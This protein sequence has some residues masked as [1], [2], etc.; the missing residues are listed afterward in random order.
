MADD[1]ENYIIK[2]SLE[3]HVS[4]LDLYTDKYRA[5]IASLMDKSLKIIIRKDNTF[6]TLRHL[7]F[8]ISWQKNCFSDII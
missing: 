5:L 2:N 7:P 1:I 4:E 3:S 8:W 6:A